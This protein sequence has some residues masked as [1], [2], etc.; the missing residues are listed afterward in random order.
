[1]WI[2]KTVGMDRLAGKDQDPQFEMV[3]TNRFLLTQ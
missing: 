1:M 2:R 3:K